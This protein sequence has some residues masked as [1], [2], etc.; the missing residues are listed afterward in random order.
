MSTT[1]PAASYTIHASLKEY[2]RRLGP[3]RI[4][5]AIAI[6]LIILVRFGLL[7]WIVSVI[8]IALFITIILL[9]LSKRQLTVTKD[10]IIYRSFIGRRYTLSFD[11]L[12]GVKVFVNYFEPTFGIT[13]RVSI[14][15]KTG[16]APIILVGL[17]WALEDMEQ[18]LTLLKK[19]KVSVEYYDDTVTYSL[20]R[21]QFPSHT[22]YVERHP[23]VVATIVVIVII[24]AAVLFFTVSVFNR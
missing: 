8:G 17:F 22:T 13:P 21:G 16:K 9:L 4:I 14:A 7:A 18:M 12:E 5:L 10:G 6:S 24:V 23:A 15:Q 1:P 11:Q 3:G 20:I 19:Q 2:T